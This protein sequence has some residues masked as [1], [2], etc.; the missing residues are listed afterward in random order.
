[1]VWYHYQYEAMMSTKD[2]NLSLNINRKRL[3]IIVVLC[4]LF[5]CVWQRSFAQWT[6]TL[7][8][9]PHVVEKPRP[10]GGMGGSLP[11][12][13]PPEFL[14]G[15][16]GSLPE[17]SPQEFLPDSVRQEPWLEVMGEPLH[18]DFSAI[19]G[20]PLRHVTQTEQHMQKAV[21]TDAFYL[22]EEKE[23]R[24]V[25]HNMPTVKSLP[26]GTLR[27]RFHFYHHVK[28]EQGYYTEATPLN[29]SAIVEE[30]YGWSN[31]W[32]CP[33]PDLDQTN[34][35]SA[36]SAIPTAVAVK[37]GQGVRRIS[38]PPFFKL[39]AP[40]DYSYHGKSTVACVNYMFGFTPPS[41]YWEMLRRYL[42]HYR[43]NRVEHFFFHL[44]EG[45]E[46]QSVLDA[47]RALG[48]DGPFAK[49]LPRNDITIILVPQ[50]IRYQAA[51]FSPTRE[52]KIERFTPNQCLYRARSAQIKWVLMQHDLDE[53]LIMEDR[54]THGN[55]DLPAYLEDLNSD[56]AYTVS[57]FVGNP[58]NGS[59][60][61]Y[62]LQENGTEVLISVKV[63]WPC[64]GTFHRCH[65][66]T[67]FSCASAA[68]PYFRQVYYQSPGRG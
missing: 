45:P 68:C 13:S 54:D 43:A 28:N 33:V 16:R 65:S 51:W 57:S 44:E 18:L 6:R 63:R 58:Q 21:L 59:V 7:A 3:S 29:V 22:S 31:I 49:E 34:H 67:C 23:V 60:V 64:L 62:P 52:D 17:P 4:T 12:L 56:V 32:A 36:I 25:V 39:R 50:S 1:M 14:P 66:H 35:T 19:P 5:V 2:R 30:L 48:E 8:V 55:F 37:L 38:G 15:R 53:W 61:P 9:E 20:G 41:K 46:V 42:N 47:L 26:E 24:F 27:C 40:H 11:D 10:E